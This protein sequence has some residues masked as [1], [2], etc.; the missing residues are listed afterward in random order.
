MEYIH[1]LSTQ[2][3]MFLFSLGFGFLLGILYDLFRVIRLT[4]SR[5]RGFTLF[6]DLLY[7]AFCT[8]LTFFFLLVLDA[9]RI[10]L[11]SL[12]GELLG[13]LVYYFSFGAVASRAGSRFAKAVKR[14]FALIFR[15]F[16]FIF[17]KTKA[18]G[19][20]LSLISKKIIKKFK[21]KQKLSC[22]NGT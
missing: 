3:R 8:V 20:N 13:F 7:F 16:V 19:K 11:Y 6:M 17:G 10:R 15:P 9:G 4:V 2:G 22:Q 5:S 1:G 12:G 18:G 14:L 21:K